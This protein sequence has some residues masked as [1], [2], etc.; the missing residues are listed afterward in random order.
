MRDPQLSPS[1]FSKDELVFRNTIVD[2]EGFG[3]ASAATLSEGICTLTGTR[4]I[5]VEVRLASEDLSPYDRLS[6]TARNRSP[7][8]VLAGIELLHRGSSPESKET[9]RSFSGGRE[10]LPPGSWTTLVFPVESFGSYG[11]D[12]AWSKVE[13]IRIAFGFDRDHIGPDCVQV[14]LLRLDGERRIIPEGPR[15]TDAGLRH[16]LGE[17][18][19]Y[20]VAFFRNA[21]GVLGNRKVVS[22]ALRCYAPTN[23]EIFFPPPHPYPQESPEEIIRGRVMGQDVGIPI[24]WRANPLGVQEWTHFLNRHHFTRELVKAFAEKRGEIYVRA[25]GEIVESWIRDNPVPLGSNGGA[26]PAWETLSTAWRLREWLW[27]VGIVWESSY[28]PSR[29]IKT[30]L[31][32][33]WEHATSLLDH[34]GHPNNWL[35]VESAALTLAG[36][37]FPWFHDAGR[38]K[39]VGLERLSVAVG[40]Q[41]FEDGVHFE[42]SPLYHAICLHCLIEVKLAA[43]ASKVPLPQE[44]TSFEQRMGEYLVALCRPDFTWPS[45][46]DSGGYLGNYSQLMARMGEVYNRQDLMWLGSQGRRGSPPGIRFRAFPCAGI[47][48]MRSHD[49]PD[50]NFLV[51]RAGPAGAA[52]VHDDVLSL[53]VA[54]LG[55]PRLVDPGV[56]SYA[57]DPLTHHYRS[58]GS[59]STIL[60]NGKGA[61]RSKA[62]YPERI[63]PAGAALSCATRQ[64]LQVAEGHWSGPWEGSPDCAVTRTVLF[65]KGEYW[66]VFDTVVCPLPEEV[67][68][69]WQ[70]SPG[71]VEMDPATSAAIYRDARGPGLKLVPL[72][73]RGFHVEIAMGATVPPRGWVS[74]NG[75]DMPALSFRYIIPTVTHAT[76]AWALVP[77]AGPPSS[78]IQ[79]LRL[80]RSD[81]SLRIEIALSRGYRDEADLAPGTVQSEADAEGFLERL[82]FRRSPG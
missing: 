67:S 8:Q 62:A 71:R 38:W 16:V 29:T 64:D 30:M 15:L 18:P 5:V 41:F 19:D 12:P 82:S 66:L 68:V 59:H 43:E 34:V 14:D 57:P 74:L 45:L 70:F 52:H 3:S 53:E 80:D 24:L 46:N 25:I 61:V 6:L 73:G 58:A 49:G 17:D 77:F 65:V 48:T 11:K 78:E 36:L 23:P 28:F 10:P 79:A 42:I 20:L 50:A 54:A 72:L 1:H 13:K 56:T 7:A 76:L 21:D 51:F 60:I 35:L 4:R 32:S 22:T 47:V 26:G 55:R 69:N 9:V 2:A 81:L 31:R 40:T 63:R 39:E 27:I 37:C 75:M 44:L 33:I